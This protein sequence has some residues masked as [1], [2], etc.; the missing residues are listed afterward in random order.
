MVLA[1]LQ[2]HFLAESYIVLTGLLLHAFQST[3]NAFKPSFA[4]KHGLAARTGLL[5]TRHEYMTVT[6]AQ[7]DQQLVE[8]LSHIPLM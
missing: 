1:A 5:H 4:S 2:N 7:D 8:P 3:V 6:K